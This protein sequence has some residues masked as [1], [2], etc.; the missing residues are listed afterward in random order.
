LIVDSRHR[1]AQA[2]TLAIE[3]KTLMHSLPS[4]MAR[5]EVFYEGAIRFL[6]SESSGTGLFAHGLNSPMESSPPEPSSF[7]ST[8]VHLCGPWG[9]DKKGRADIAPLE[10]I[11]PRAITAPPCLLERPVLNFPKQE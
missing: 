7:S 9:A 8:P 6:L 10:K 2:E 1:D 5:G 3:G 11:S 4:K